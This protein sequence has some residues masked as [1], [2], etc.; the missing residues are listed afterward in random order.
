M[1]KCL[2]IAVGAT[3]LVGSSVGAALLSYEPFSYGT[4][5]NLFG[6]GA[7]GGT[8]FGGGWNA[9][10]GSQGYLN[11][12][13]SGTLS[14]PSALTSIGNH[15]TLSAQEG[16]ELYSGSG[17][18]NYLARAMNVNG[19]FA[20]YSDGS[21]IGADG[22]TLWGSFLYTG[23][24]DAGANPLQIT[25]NTTS[26]HVLNYHLPAG[27]AGSLAVFKL[28]FGA[29]GADTASFYINPVSFDPNTAVP[30]ATL[31]GTFGFSGIEFDIATR[32]GVQF[33]GADIDEI[34]FGDTAVDVATVVVAPEPGSAM[35]LMGL[36]GL[37]LRRRR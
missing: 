24:N 18:I 13:R 6:G 29:G 33:N 37:A 36:G 4:P 14:A 8:G 11:E 17:A 1:K 26:A 15:A 7:N 21:N 25:L 22:T 34:R 27:G 10:F 30:T 5:T 20:S 35:L 31:T 32:S 28:S 9:G 23:S 16:L 3:L 19:A 2:L 12:V